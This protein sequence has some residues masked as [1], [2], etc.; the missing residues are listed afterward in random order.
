MASLTPTPKQQIFGSDGLPLVGGKIYTYAA[1][2]TT[3]LATYTDAGAGTANTNP[4][5]LNSLGQANI[6]LAPASSYKFSV[7]TSA[8]VLLYTVDNIV[9]PIDYLSLVTSLA[10]PPPIGSTAPNTGAFTTL[11]ATTGTI[12][13]VNCTTITAET[14][15]FEGGGSMTKPPESGIQPITATV[16]ADALTV[17]LNPTTLDFRSAALTSGAVVSRLISSAISVTVSSGSTLG[18]VSATQSQIVVLALDN[19][20]T[21]ELAVV[22]IAGGNDLSETGVISTTAEGGAGAADSAST[23]YSTTARSDVAYRVVGYVESTQATAGT[24]A[25]APSTIQGYGGQ[26]YIRPSSGSVVRVHTANGYGSTNTCIR[27]FS[28]I[29]TNQGS[30]ITYADSATLGASFTINTNGVYAISFSDQFN[31]SDFMGISLNSNQL[32]TSIANITASTRIAIT[33]T[34]ANADYPGNCG[35]TLYLT[36]G[37]VIR[38]HTDADPS[39]TV[40][41]LT[42][43]TISRVA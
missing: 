11:T 32:T 27:R 37:D 16:A 40:P 25:T 19:A 26:A 35:V 3:P 23:I 4:I 31:G 13:T 34:A 21:V 8:D 29:V 5:I 22:N 24:W 6:W 1:G 20:G 30:D 42:T 33:T 38:A 18:T 2:T 17:T 10:S 14:L 7:Y 39:G 36:V 15:T 9:T 43:F 28:T 12:T 41:A